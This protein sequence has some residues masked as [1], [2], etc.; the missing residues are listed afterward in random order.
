MLLL[1]SNTFNTTSFQIILHKRYDKA[2]RINT[3]KLDHKINFFQRFECNY[4]RLVKIFLLYKVNQ[5]L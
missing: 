5:D 3:T 2:V 4:A 1:I